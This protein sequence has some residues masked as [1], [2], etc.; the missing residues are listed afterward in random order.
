MPRCHNS[1]ARPGAIAAA[2]SKPATDSVIR[3]ARKSSVALSITAFRVLPPSCADID[4]VPAW[5]R[6]TAAASAHTIMR[7]G[8][9][10]A[11][12]IEA[13]NRA[14]IGF[15][16]AFGAGVEEAVGKCRI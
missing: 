11:A 13:D 15:F 6:Q 5:T 16:V 4:R 12:K 10:S 9:R 3:A 8:L 7:R 1:G 2:R 14:L